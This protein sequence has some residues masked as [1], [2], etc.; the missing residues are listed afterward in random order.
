MVTSVAEV[1]AWRGLGDLRPDVERALSRS[2]RDKS[3]LDDLV[4]DT[5]L[6]AARFRRGLH[7]HSRLKA[8]VMRIAWNVLHDHARREGRLNR[9]ETGEEFLAELEGRESPPGRSGSGECITVAGR[10]YDRDE[11]LD[12]VRELVPQLSSC[13]RAL[14]DVYYR[15]GL[16]CDRAAAELRIPIPTIKMRLFRLRKRVARELLRRTRHRLGSQ[17]KA[18]EV[19]A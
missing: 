7:D 4:Q 8:W 9:A 2:C 14:F 10:L 16:G 19:I 6:R 3:E 15:R 13:D 11:M 1:G 5:L 18:C 17:G 12:L